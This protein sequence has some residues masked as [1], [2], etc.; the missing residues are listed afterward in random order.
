[1]FRKFIS[2][3]LVSKKQFLIIGPLNA[4]AYNDLFLSIK[5]NEVWIGKNFRSGSVKF[6]VPHIKNNTKFDENSNPYTAIQGIR[7]F[8]NIPTEVKTPLLP[9]TKEYT[10]EDYPFYVNYEA[11][12][13]DKVCD[14]P[15]DYYGEMGV[16]ISFIDKYNPEQF[17]II[18]RG[19]GHHINFTNRRKMETLTG[20]QKGRIVINA[21]ENLY[22]LHNPKKDKTPPT[23]R[24]CETGDLYQSIYVRFIIK[25]KQS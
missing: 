2:L 17:E 5:N 12:N 18:A 3:L 25:R 13:I 16:P 8:T 20:K 24:D 6:I 22:R 4:V 23:F 21:K 19:Y 1:M 7:W 10:E 15:R 14:I 9:L 11:I